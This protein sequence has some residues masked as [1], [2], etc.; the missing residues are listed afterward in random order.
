MPRPLPLVPTNIKFTVE[1]RKYLKRVARTQGHYHLSKVVKA[2][3]DREMQ[4]A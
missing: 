3:V 1:Q 4:V 2:L